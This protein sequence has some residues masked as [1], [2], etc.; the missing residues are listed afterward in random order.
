MTAQSPITRK[1][2]SSKS[3]SSSEIREL[4]QSLFV[5]ELL[6]PSDRL[7]LVSPWMT[8]LEILDNRDGAYSALMPAVG[9]RHIRLSEILTTLLDR[10]RLTIVARPDDHNSAFLGKLED[11]AAS[12][13]LQVKLKVMRRDTL[14]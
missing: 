14:H 12:L 3:T 4:L 5:S 6:R 10:T 9:L 11:L 2:Y 7:W 1:I 8:D 13:S